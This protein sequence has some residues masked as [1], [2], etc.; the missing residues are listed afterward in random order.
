MVYLLT[1]CVQEHRAEKGGGCLV[2]SEC[3][4]LKQ[5]QSRVSRLER[6][7]QEFLNAVFHR[8]GTHTHAQMFEL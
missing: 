8:K 6:Q 7:A 3:E 5:E 2:L 4:D 1:V